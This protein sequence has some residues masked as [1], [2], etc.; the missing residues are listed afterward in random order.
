M[1]AAVKS[2]FIGK[3]SS[4]PAERPFIFTRPTAKTGLTSW[5]TTVDHKRVGLLYGVSS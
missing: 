1:Q 3:E 4:A 2:D 5:L